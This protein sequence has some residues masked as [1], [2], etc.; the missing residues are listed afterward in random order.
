MNGVTSYIVHN[1][2]LEVESI[3]VLRLASVTVK[4]EQIV[5]R[6]INFNNISADLLKRY[7][8][9]PIFINYWIT[10]KVDC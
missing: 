6:H 9:T 4:N 2:F 1:L 5:K 8:R 3:I 10:L 7:F